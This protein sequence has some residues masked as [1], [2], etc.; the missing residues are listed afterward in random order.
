MSHQYIL[1]DEIPELRAWSQENGAKLPLLRDVDSSYYLRQEKFGMNLGPYERD[2]RAEWVEAQAGDVP[3]DF[4]FQLWPDD[5]ERLEWYLEDACARVPILATAGLQKV[6]NGPIPYTPDG[7]PLIGP[8]PGVP[9]AWEAATFTF[10]I[11]QAGGAGKVLAEWVTQGRTEWDMW[12]CDP[13][14][15]TAHA[16][17]PDYAVAKAKEVYGHEYA[18]HFPHHHWPAGRPQKVSP[19]HERVDAISAPCGARSTAGSARSGS[20]NPGDDTSLE[21]HRGVD[22][23]RPLG[24]A[25][26][27]GM[28]GR[29]RR[30]RHPRPAGLLA[31]QRGRAGRRGMARCADH[32][33]GAAR[34]PRRTRAISATRAGGSSPRCRWCGMARTSSRS[35]PPPARNGTT[36]NGSNARCR[37]A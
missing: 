23:L 12:A 17:E 14:R 34:G 20:R 1:F 36:A 13:R 2:A 27:R 22:P 32:R 7:N 5:L 29:A 30:L 8:M 25:R 15:F 18:M 28:R 10:G 19:V 3:E 35:S 37:T 11:C 6:I 21:G 24:G 33:H 9:N 16:S 4:S 26:A 31:L